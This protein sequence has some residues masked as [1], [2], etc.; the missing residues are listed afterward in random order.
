MPLK[1]KNPGIDS[2]EMV[3]GAVSLCPH[4]SSPK[5]RCQERPHSHD[6]FHREDWEHVS[7]CPGSPAGQ[8]AT[9]ETHFFLTSP[10]LLRG[11]A[12]LS[13]GRSWEYSSQ[14]SEFS[15]GILLIASWFCLL[16]DSQ[17]LVRKSLHEKWWMPHMQPPQRP[18]HMHPQRLTAPLLA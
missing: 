3:R 1:Q 5:A 7:E 17:T 8:D 16:T 6:F 15:K 12:T 2:L 11:S 4:H 13:V 10:R 14:G 9:Q 18:P